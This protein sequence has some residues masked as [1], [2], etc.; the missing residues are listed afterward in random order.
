MRDLNRFLTL[1]RQYIADS[2]EDKSIEKCLSQALETS[3]FMRYNAND[4]LSKGLLLPF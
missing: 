2:N 1:F 4:Q 3:Y